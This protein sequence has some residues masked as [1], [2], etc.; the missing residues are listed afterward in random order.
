MKKKNS[1]K[2]SDFADDNKNPSNILIRIVDYI[3]F[4]FPQFH[5]NKGEQNMKNQ[6]NETS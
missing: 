4:R 3:I 6:L 1:S 2:G 5:T